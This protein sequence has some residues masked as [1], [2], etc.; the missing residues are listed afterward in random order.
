[1]NKTLEQLHRKAPLTFHQVTSEFYIV[2]NRRHIIIRLNIKT[3]N[4]DKLS[5]LTNPL[6]S[7]LSI[8]NKVYA[9]FWKMDTLFEL[10]QEA[11]HPTVNKQITEYQCADY[12]HHFNFQAL[13]VKHLLNCQAKSFYEN[14]KLAST[15]SLCC[16]AIIIVLIFLLTL[17]FINI[18][19][20]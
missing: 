19:K 11:F 18:Q 20:V 5:T 10:K 15:L 8:E 16:I 17:T 4:K 14:R 9:V 7:I 13:S 6:S 1:M 12:H 2:D 3:G